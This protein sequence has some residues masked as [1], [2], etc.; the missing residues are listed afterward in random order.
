IDR[1]PGPVLEMRTDAGIYRGVPISRRHLR[2]ARL[3]RLLLL[4]LC[5]VLGLAFLKLE[6]AYFAQNFWR[7]RTI[8]RSTERM[9]TFVDPAHI[10]TSSRTRRV[11]RAAVM[12]SSK[13]KVPRFRSALHPMRAWTSMTGSVFNGATPIAIASATMPSI[14]PTERFFD[15]LR[16]PASF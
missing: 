15:G 8:E 3:A 16:L 12:A 7:L 4:V 9:N 1:G 5:G 14:R 11:Y 2:F 13:S 6:L 10:R